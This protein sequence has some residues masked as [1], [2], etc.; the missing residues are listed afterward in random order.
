VAVNG[1]I[2]DGKIIDK[3]QEENKFSNIRKK[4]ITTVLSVIFVVVAYSMYRYGN[5]EPYGT[6]LFITALIASIFTLIMELYLYY[7]YWW[8]P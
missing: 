5:T 4:A 1:R 2:I 6:A 7:K 8:S 3:R